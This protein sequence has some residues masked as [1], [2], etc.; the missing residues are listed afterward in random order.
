MIFVGDCD[1]DVEVADVPGA[2]VAHRAADISGMTGT[3]A[4]VTIESNTMAY[5]SDVSHDSIMKIDNMCEVDTNILALVL[6]NIDVTEIFSSERVTTLCERFGLTPRSSTDLMS[7]WDV[8]FEQDRMRAEK[9]VKAEKPNLLIGSPPCT[10]FS[11]LQSLTQ[12]LNRDNAEL[13]EHFE[14]N[15]QKSIRHIRCGCHLYNIK[16]GCRTLFS[17]EHAWSAGSWDLD[18]MEELLSYGRVEK[19]LGHICQF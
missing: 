17:H 10:H 5:T 3:E 13:L 9:L 7:G 16:N 14:M 12:C 19:V 8:D 15:I 6:C 18:E 1:S 11:I 2:I 4:D